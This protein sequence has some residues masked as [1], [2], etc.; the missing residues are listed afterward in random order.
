MGNIQLLL[1]MLRLGMVLHSWWGIMKK[2]L[3]VMNWLRHSRM[4][5]MESERPWG[6]SIYQRVAGGCIILRNSI[7]RSRF[8]FLLVRKNLVLNTYISTTCRRKLRNKSINR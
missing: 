4:C 1:E 2:C 8:K 5:C 6:S 3:M 7:L